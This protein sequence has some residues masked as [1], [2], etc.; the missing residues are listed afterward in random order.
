MNNRQRFHQTMNF[1][2][3]DRIL[4]FEEGIRE[5]VVK[6]WYKQGLSKNQN[7]SDIF[8]TDR[9]IEIQLNIDPL[10]EIIKWPTTFK[11]LDLLGDRLDP[12]NSARFPSKWQNIVN[13]TRN[14]D[15]VIFLRVHR[16]FFQS[17]GIYNWDRFYEVMY[18][19]LENPEIVLQMMSIYGNFLAKFFDKLLNELKVDA[20][21]FSEPICG[22]EGPL[23]S[24]EMYEK[25]ALMSYRP[26]LDVLNKHAIRTK[27]IRTYANARILLP[28]LI[29]NGF[30]CLWACET[31]NK[32]MDYRELRREFGNELSLIGGIDL[33]ALRKG[34]DAI[35]LEINE[36]VPQ[37]I[38]EGGY[39]PLAD[40]RIREDILYENYAYYR[41]L[42]KE[43]INVV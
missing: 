42:L 7:L 37:L 41:T 8:P 27:I 14:N 12:N 32:A 3:S 31:N 2:S 38:A 13:D 20:A 21:I 17:I 36:K 16:G 43:V 28:T 10:P 33:D 15:K 25:F 24:P 23:I 29:K 5:G 4:Y 6:Q 11:E 30:N 26:M 40:G 35:K 22:N 19:L 34:K 39:I 1:S 18:M 9:F